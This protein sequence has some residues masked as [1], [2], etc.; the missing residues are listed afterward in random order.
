MEE[1]RPFKPNVPFFQLTTYNLQPTTQ[2]PQPKPYL[3]MQSP[4]I[5]RS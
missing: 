2:N 5:R 3:N 4:I 1:N